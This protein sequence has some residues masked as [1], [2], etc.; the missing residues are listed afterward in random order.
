MERIIRRVTPAPPTRPPKRL[1]V[2]AYA[3]VSM[4]KDTM[5]HSLS[6]QVSYYNAY[7]QRNPVW[8]FAGVYADNACTGTRADRPEF[9]RL[10]ADCRAGKIDRI[11]TKSV[12]RF[13]RN[14]LALLQVTRELKGLG[15]DVYFEKENIHSLGGDGELML[16]LL[17]SFAQEESYSV[18]ENCKWQI[19]KRFEQGIPTTT[20]MNG[21][22][23]DHGEITPIPGEAE[24]VRLIF[25]LRDQGLG[26]IAIAKE[27]NARGIPAKNGGPWT[28][29]CLSKILRN[30][31]YC[32][33]LLLQKQFRV[34]HLE[35]KDKPNEGELPMY[36]VRDNHE[37][38][39]PRE[40]FNSVHD[41]IYLNRLT[42]PEGHGRHASYPFSS[43]L[44]CAY[45]GKHYRRRKNTGF[46]AWQC[47]TF[48]TYGKDHCPARQVREEIL[49]Q[50]A[51][52]ALGMDHFDAEAFR[53]RI[54]HVLVCDERILKFLFTD[55]HA[56]EFRW[57]EP[58][59]SAAWT[60][61]KRARASER[62]RAG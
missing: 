62:R 36:E 44:V 12:S 15:I 30:E 56:E 7:I 27:L 22:R 48:M 45:C 10:L 6:T 19:R 2:A 40:L 49:E 39:V 55:G 3:R 42:L 43:K 61:E 47:N 4:D 14:T 16:S 1:R 21:L 18:S 11:I 57:Q 46:I 51:A 53:E 32:G 17:A 33:D 59:R 23:I 37:A 60:Q 41:A 52:L 20:R 28:E 29:G 26:R 54:D 24:T 35:K 5:F 25:Q 58:S 31:K 13:A 8:E 38:I 50:Y 9:Q 34:D